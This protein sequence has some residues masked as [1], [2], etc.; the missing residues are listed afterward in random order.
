MLPTKSEAK[1]SSKNNQAGYEAP[2]VIYK[3]ALNDPLGTPFHMP[4]PELSAGRDW[5]QLKNLL[6]LFNR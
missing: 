6:N 3:G 4:D 5:S 1:S 2:S